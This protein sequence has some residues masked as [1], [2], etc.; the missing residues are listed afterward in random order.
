MSAGI[1]DKQAS[2][3][4]RRLLYK[5]LVELQDAGV[6]CHYSRYKVRNGAE[7]LSF[8]T[9]S[10]PVAPGPWFFIEY[11]HGHMS[12]GGSVLTPWV[13]ISDGTGSK[14]KFYGSLD[15]EKGFKRIKK[16][17]AVPLPVEQ[18]A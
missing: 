2:G 17:F 14:P 4:K 8:E 6:T 11:H 10:L 1:S 16:L 9:P 5:L 13:E 15:F 18:G 7:P 3:Y 12:N